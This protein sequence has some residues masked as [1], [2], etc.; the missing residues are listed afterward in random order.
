MLYDT[1]G[2]GNEQGQWWSPTVFLT[3]KILATYTQSTQTA[4]SN[5][6]LRA[7]QTYGSDVAILTNSC[8]LYCV[9]EL[10]GKS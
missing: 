8:T 1:S 7:V 6:D 5:P 3:V 9:H 4:I 2:E 10:N